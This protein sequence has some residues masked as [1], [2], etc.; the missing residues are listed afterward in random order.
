M[1]EDWLAILRFD[2]E[3]NLQG[4]LDSPE[5]QALLRESAAFTEEFHARIVRTGFEQ[6]FAGAGG[7]AAAG[8]RP[9][10]RTWWFC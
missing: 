10:S 6:W 2:S 8:R 5:R 4:W 9:G 3:A 7:A 1:Q